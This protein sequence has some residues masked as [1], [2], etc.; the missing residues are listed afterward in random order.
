MKL[1]SDF[2]LRDDVVAISRDLLGKVLC[3]KIGGSLTRTMIT[4]TE[5][6]AGVS[7][8]ASHAYGGRRTKRTEPLFEEGGIA[9]VYLC[10]G[11]HHLFNVVT[12]KAGAPHA[13]LIRAGAPLSGTKLM[14]QRREKPTAD[15]SLLAGPG[16]LARALGITTEDTGA[17]L[18]NG[19]IWI[20]DQGVDIDDNSVTVGP[21]V[22]VDYAG[23][24]AFRPYRFRTNAL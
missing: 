18:M 11:I 2:Y 1:V 22:G 9:Y 24:D 4:E 7:D 15:Q 14:L 8:K 23:D 12:N 13:V 21:R 19:R 6:Y 16:S 17:S 3:T 10:Y 5:A 20:E